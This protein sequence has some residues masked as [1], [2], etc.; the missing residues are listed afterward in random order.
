M[1]NFAIWGMPPASAT[2]SPVRPPVSRVQR[3]PYLGDVC[4]GGTAA[5]LEGR[6]PGDTRRRR[7]GDA[8]AAIGCRGGSSLVEDALEAVDDGRGARCLSGG[9]SARPEAPSSRSWGTTPALQARRVIRDSASPA[10]F[11]ADGSGEMR[12]AAPPRHSTAIAQR[13]AEFRELQIWVILATWPSSTITRQSR[14]SSDGCGPSAR[15]GPQS[16]QIS[17]M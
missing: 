3:S 12:R 11:R 4:F 9:Y 5:L 8:A 16:L 1:L 10:L 7:G 13:A 17:R 6:H 2:R 15:Q 14:P